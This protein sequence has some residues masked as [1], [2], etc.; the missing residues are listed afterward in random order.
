M[1]ASV[2]TYTSTRTQTATHLSDAILGTFS[3]ILATLGLGDSYLARYWATIENGLTIWIEEESLEDV[4]LEI[5]SPSNPEAVFEVPIGYRTTGEGNREFVTSQ[6]RLA[7]AMAKFTSAP[8]GADYRVVVTHR[9]QHTPV[10]GWSST[11]LADTSRL[12]AYHLGSLASGPDASA[13]LTYLSR[14]I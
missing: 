7:R 3:S 10:S 6:A 4:R 11:T 14:R 2:G 13:S 9:C 12:S 1:S 8:A 5:G